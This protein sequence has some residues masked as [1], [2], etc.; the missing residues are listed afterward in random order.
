[1]TV[2]PEMR[3]RLLAECADTIWTMRPEA[4]AVV[5]AFA[6]STMTVEE[7]R[8]QM[9][10][11][12]VEE[13]TDEP[14]GAIALIPLRGVITP[15]G[16]FLDMLFGG[17]RGLLDFRASLRAAVNDPAI[18]AIL[19]D[20]DSPGGSVSMTPEAAA[21]VRAA[22]AVK[23]IVAS[24]NAMAASGAYYIASQADELVMTPSG[25]VGSIGVFSTHGEISKLEERIGIKTTLIHAAAS[26]R[27]TDG[28]MYEPLS[29]EARADIQAIVDEICEEFIADVAAGRG[30]SADDVRANYG[31]GACL[32]APAAL[33]AGMVDRVE[34]IET[35]LE[36]LFAGDVDRKDAAKSKAAKPAPRAATASATQATAIVR[37]GLGEQLRCASFVTPLEM[38]APAAGVAG[39]AWVSAEAQY[40]SRTS[41][42]EVFVPGWAKDSIARN[43]DPVPM[44]DMHR[45]AIGSWRDR[46]E[47]RE[48]LALAGAISD[49]PAGQQVA[50][51][52]EDEA[53]NGLSVGFWP[54]E[55]YLAGPGEPVTFD[56]PYGSW[57]HTEAKWT[58]Y[59]IRGDLCEASIVYVPADADARVTGIDRMSAEQLGTALPGLRAGA[60]W[61]DVA[62]SMCRLMGAPGAGL[63]SLGPH[64]R[65]A[66]HAQLRTRYAE[67]GRTAPV[68]AAQPDYRATTFHADE[69]ELYR[70]RSLGKRCAD[71]VA[72]A[73]GISDRPLSDGTRTRLGEARN[74]ITQLL[75]DEQPDPTG[76]DAAATA[77]VTAEL[78]RVLAT[79]Q[80]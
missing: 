2:T 17:P 76:L 10:L 6:N 15:R 61:G 75:G 36:R 54:D 51:L 47:N 69:P 18:E 22:R 19:L 33:A 7:A 50:T 65:Q 63:N 11:E 34:T 71:V 77:A 44:V 38:A 59:V 23:P 37:A 64:E 55:T 25:I 14:S 58:L 53:M 35:T 48:R 80:S 66:L 20:V 27:K 21:A 70:D 72:A 30:V 26:P 79:L 45:Q 16:S 31:Q 5:Q 42:G 74:A 60:S 32:R 56:T 24:A 13:E 46:D 3:A 39:I 68:F 40:G 67:H 62:Y 12:T 57:S 78:E 41:F 28:N 4:L 49:T 8:R 1:M 29:A 73:G 9:G 43:R 52:L